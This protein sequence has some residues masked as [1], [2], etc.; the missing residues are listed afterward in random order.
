M[1]PRS[2]QDV[3]NRLDFWQALS[4]GLLAIFVCFHLFFEGTVVI[5]PSITNAIAWIMEEI[6]LA[7]VAAPVVLLLIVF[8]FWIAARKMPFRQGELAIFIDHSRALKDT[9]TWLW[10][11]QVFTAVVILVGAFFHV[12]TVMTDLPINVAESAKRLHDGWMCFFVVFLPCTI[13]HTGI[14]IFRI[15]AKYGVCTRATRRTWTRAIWIGMGCYL[16]LGICA[17]TRTWFYN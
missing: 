8:H 14:G 5:S 7:Q 13:L 1:T 3:R 15:A 6:Y 11:V 17:L 4:G 9:D 16:V 2:P 12:Y 10:L